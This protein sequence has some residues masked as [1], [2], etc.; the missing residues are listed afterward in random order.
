VSRRV[1]IIGAS[2]SGKTRLVARLI[3]HL[4]RRGKRVGTVKHAHHGFD[5]DKRGKDSHRHFEAG[6]E[7]VCLAGPEKTAVFKRHRQP[8]AL[9]DVWANLRSCDVVLVEGFR[10]EG[11]RA[12]E[13]YRKKISPRPYYKSRKIRVQAVVSRDPVDFKGPVFDPDD[14]RKIA[15]W[16]LK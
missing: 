8:P 15:D 4:K 10:S 1:A 14:L 3:R 16:I 13:V 9:K 5:M 11:L 12:L 6:A 2:G 7:V